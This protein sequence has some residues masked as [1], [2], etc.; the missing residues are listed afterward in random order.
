MLAA[1][2]LRLLSRLFALAGSLL[3]AR[4]V[5]NK[6]HIQKIV[7][8]LGTT[9]NNVKPETGAKL[10]QMKLAQ[11]FDQWELGNDSR[12]IKNTIDK[13]KNQHENNFFVH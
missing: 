6:L 9:Q 3:P 8:F 2:L 11:C 1:A 10:R 4:A 13:K 12:A 5:Q 7:A